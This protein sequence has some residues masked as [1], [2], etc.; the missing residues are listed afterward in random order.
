[1]SRK[2][3]T[4]VAEERQRQDT[5]DKGQWEMAGRIDVVSRTIRA[6]PEAI[7][8]AFS[9]RHALE[10]WLPPAGMRAQAAG[11]EFREGGGYRMRLVYLDPHEAPGKSSDDADDVEVRFV[12]LQAPHLVEQEVTF[13][14]LKAEYH[15]VM[16]MRWTLDPAEGGTEVTVTCTNVPGGITRV[17]HEEGISSSLANLAAYVAG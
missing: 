5:G 10:T 17:D 7:F 6:T 11:F 8:Q 13:K 16:I 4:G 14:S 12:R 3:G 1:M 2:P 15:G 9:D